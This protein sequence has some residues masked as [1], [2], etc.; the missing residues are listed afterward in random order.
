MPL[1]RADVALFQMQPWIFCVMTRWHWEHGEAAMHNPLWR[2]ASPAPYWNMNGYGARHYGAIHLLAWTHWIRIRE[3]LVDGDW[4]GIERERRVAGSAAAGYRRLCARA[5]PQPNQRNTSIIFILI[6]LKRLFAR[7]KSD[8]PLTISDIEYITRRG[9]RIKLCK[10]MIPTNSVPPPRA[11]CWKP[12]KPAPAPNI[13][14]QLDCHLEFG[15]VPRQTCEAI[16][17]LGECLV[18]VTI[19][20]GAAAF[21]N[22]WCDCSLAL[23]LSLF[24]S[25]VCAYAGR[26]VCFIANLFRGPPDPRSALFPVRRPSCLWRGANGH[27]VFI[28]THSHSLCRECKLKFYSLWWRLVFLIGICVCAWCSLWMGGWWLRNMLN[29]TWWR[30]WWLNE[31]CWQLVLL[32]LTTWFFDGSK[33]V[34]F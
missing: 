15:L 17:K 31:F 33:N 3:A 5:A 9:L 21:S 28:V 10:M 29:F 25:S 2:A 6:W 19:I 22:Q 14:D 8:P 1:L 11:R 18:A 4:G 12:A 16:I 32:E 26:R 27:S 13:Y 30:N 24:W 7:H 34:W 20:A 23:S